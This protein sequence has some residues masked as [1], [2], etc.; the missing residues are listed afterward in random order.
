MEAEE[1][2]RSAHETKKAAAAMIADADNRIMQVQA[3]IDEVEKEAQQ[4]KEASQ[5]LA[6]AETTAASV[7]ASARR[8]AAA[9]LEREREQVAFAKLDRDPGTRLLLLVDL[10]ST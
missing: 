2:K 1:A 6:D 7:V 8:E 4:N 10:S 5:V 3:M 9:L